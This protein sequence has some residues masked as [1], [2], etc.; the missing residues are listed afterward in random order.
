M[1]SAIEEILYGIHLNY[2]IEMNGLELAIYGYES[3]VNYQN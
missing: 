2:D 1:D 3:L